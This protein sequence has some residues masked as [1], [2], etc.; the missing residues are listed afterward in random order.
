MKIIKALF[1]ADR[2]RVGNRIT[3]TVTVPYGSKIVYC[4]ASPSDKG[5]VAVWAES[6][7]IV[8]SKQAQVSVPLIILRHDDEVPNGAVFRG[9]LLANPIL[10]IYE[11]PGVTNG[12]PN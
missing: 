10:L 5:N 11:L 7:S 12:E 8:V 6:P 1:V 3:G 4:G 9:H 2:I